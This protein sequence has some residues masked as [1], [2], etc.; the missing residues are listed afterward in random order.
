MVPSCRPPLLPAA[1]ALLV[2]GS[3]ALLPAQEVEPPRFSETI[4]VREIEVV[5]DDDV[6]PRLGSFLRKKR[7]D[8]SAFE[9]GA[10]YPLVEI[11]SV[12][13]EDW[14][15]VLYFDSE[16]AGPAARAAAARALQPLAEELIAGGRAEIVVAD[17]LP[18]VVLATGLAAELVQGLEA[19]VVQALGESEARPDSAATIAQRSRQLDRLAVELAG[20]GGGG[21]RALWLAA[22]RWPLSPVDHER[23]AQVR[24]KGLADDPQ[25]G[26]LLATGKVLAS[27]GWVTSAIAIRGE[28]VEPTMGLD[29]G[30]VQ[31][32]RG[33]TGD[34]QVS[35]PVW[36]LT[37]SRK[38]P[39]ATTESQLD[40]VT[41]FALFPLAALARPT[42]GALIGT[43]ERLGSL[44]GD[45]QDRRR[46]TYHGP[47]PEP[48]SLTTFEVRWTG[49]DGRVLPSPR[50][51]RSSTPQEVT[52]ARLRLLLAGD[53]PPA[54]AGA[55]SLREVA[56][57]PGT[58]EICFGEGRQR[59]VRLAYALPGTAED[60]REASYEIPLPS[61]LT[62]EGREL[63]LPFA[64]PDFDPRTRLSWVAEDLDNETWTGGVESRPSP[65]N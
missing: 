25:F 63:C 62:G 20:R 59:S 3:T 44:L 5:F 38:H 64:P 55:I 16:L 19:I 4:E 49:G 10:S 45:L 29:G 56:S 11:G 7:R 57:P 18:R 22:D 21:P 14:M 42:S 52:R 31:T 53:P 1:A 26:P 58:R 60:D 12:S 17:P 36:T 6:L 35:Y 43:P 34:Y 40:T 46:A 50:F 32:R 41:D 23:F 27:Y 61:V 39:D 28:R 48:G 33:G 37:G 30:R 8:Y 24:Q 9:S 15:H 47:R 54:D 2:F 13:A 65:Q 51:L